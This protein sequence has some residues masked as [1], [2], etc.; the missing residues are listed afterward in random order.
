MSNGVKGFKSFK[1]SSGSESRPGAA[2]P[3]RL[4]SPFTTVQN[5]AKTLCFWYFYTVKTFTTVWPF[6]T[7]CQTFQVR[8]SRLSRLVVPDF[9]G[10]WSDWTHEPG[11]SGPLQLSKPLQKHNVFDPYADK[12]PYNCPKHCIK[13]SVFVMFKWTGPLTTVQHTAKT[14]CCWPLCW[15]DPLQLSITVRKNNVFF[16]I[17][18]G[19]FWE[20]LFHALGLHLG[21]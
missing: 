1:T 4:R 9:P 10:W 5:T 19:D 3:L 16:V 8:E 6:T 15:H 21:S 7:D 11:K 2:E 13:H 14:R 17:I 12:T 18:L 20:P